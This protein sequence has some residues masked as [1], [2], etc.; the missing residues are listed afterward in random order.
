[1]VAGC[2]ANQAAY[3]AFKNPSAKVV[4]IDV[5]QPSL[6]HLQYL[7]DRH[8]LQNLEPHLLPIEELSALGLDFDLVVCVGGLHH[9]ADPVQGMQALAGCLRRDGVASVMLYRPWTEPRRLVGAI[10]Q[11][12]NSAAAAQTTPAAIRNG[13]DDGNRT[14]VFSLGS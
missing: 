2:G 12:H 5:S 9:L 11:G 14:R 7:K 4:G 10:G 1:L 6:D 13:A 3:F 8:G